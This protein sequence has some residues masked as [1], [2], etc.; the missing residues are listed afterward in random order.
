MQVETVPLASL[1]EDPANARK[2]APKNLEAIKGSLTKFGQQK[3]IVV[4]QNNV[5]IAGNGTLRAAR[6]L[7]WDTIDINRSELEGTEAMAFALADNRSGELA[8]WDA[9]ILGETLQG[10]LDVDFDVGSIGFDLDDLA[11]MLPSEEPSEG[12]TDPDELPEAVETRVKPGDIWMLGKHRL[13]CGDATNAQHVE[14]LMA[15]QTAIL[16]VTD[17]PYGVEYDATWREEALGDKCMAPTRTGKVANDDRSDWYDVWAICNAQIAYIWHASA[18]SDVVMDSLRRA[19]FEVRQ[20]IIW[21]KSVIAMSRSAYHWKHEPCWYAVR[22]G[23]DANWQGDRKQTTV[24]DA[25]SPT[26]IMSGSKE[27][28]TPHPTQKPSCLYEIPI[29]NH[30]RPSDCLYEPFSGSGTAFIACEKTGRRC[31]GLEID[32]HYCDVIITRWE[33]FTGLTATLETECQTD[34]TTLPM[35]PSLKPSRSPSKGRSKR[36]RSSANA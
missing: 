11:A 21:H 34:S 19:E 15:G 26:H 4:G 17:P 23:K 32:P 31:F 7:G 35:I 6:A 36:S 1:V 29:E 33:A 30:T 16:M 18:F 2:H 8:E 14:R 28:K 13:I 20:Q 5:V 12:L 9:A 3:L 10:L 24:W 22:K 25:A 27:V